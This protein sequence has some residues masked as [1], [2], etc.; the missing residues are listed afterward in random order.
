MEIKSI[1]YVWKCM[2]IYGH[3]AGITD[4]FLHYPLLIFIYDNFHYLTM[5]IIAVAIDLS[6][7]KKTEKWSKGLLNK[8]S[9][10]LVLFCVL[11]KCIGEELIHFSFKRNKS[12]EKF[13]P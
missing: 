1:N 6:I 2:M 4:V 10:R 11:I 13:F 9:L 7:L 3:I 8:L 12:L 5:K